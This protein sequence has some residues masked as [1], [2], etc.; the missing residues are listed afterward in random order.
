MSVASFMTPSVKVV[1]QTKLGPQDGWRCPKKWL[2]R[3]TANGI[4]AYEI[5]IEEYIGNMPNQK[6]R[7][8]SC[9]WAFEPIVVIKKGGVDAELIY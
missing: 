9:E 6:K 7:I 3:E 1:F 4:F 8:G 5:E 2:T